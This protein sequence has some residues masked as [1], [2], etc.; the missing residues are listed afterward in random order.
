MSRSLLVLYLRHESI[1][2]A[3][4]KFVTQIQVD[5]ADS[6][7]YLLGPTSTQPPTAMNFVIMYPGQGYDAPKHDCLEVISSPCHHLTTRSRP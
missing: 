6:Q 3:S 2:W 7:D 5:F 1:G 4:H